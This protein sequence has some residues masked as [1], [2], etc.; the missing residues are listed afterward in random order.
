MLRVTPGHAVVLVQARHVY[1]GRQLLITNVLHVLPIDGRPLC[2]DAASSL[3][4]TL[5]ARWCIDTLAV[6]QEDL[7]L[8][9]RVKSVC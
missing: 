9:L 8:S 6:M 7:N 5:R 1:E 4:W 2:A 3:V